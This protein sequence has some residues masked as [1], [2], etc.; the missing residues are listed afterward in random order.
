MK[1]F[2]RKAF[3]IVIMIFG[4][5]FSAS[6]QSISLPNTLAVLQ[7]TAD[8]LS[9]I[10]AKSL[11]FNSS[12]GLNWADAYVGKLV[13]S[14]P[15]HFGIGASF[16]VTTIDFPI[17]S[18]LTDMFGFKLPMSDLKLFKE[19]LVLPA[20]AA[21]ARIGG[22][23]LPFDIGAK[24][25]M[26]PP[27]KWLKTSYELDY[28]MAGADLRFAILDGKSKK[29][30]PNL[31]AGVGFNYLRGGL[32]A[33]VT[34][35]APTFD[36]ENPIDHI[37]H[38]LKVDDPTFRLFWETYGIEGKVQISKSFF[39]IT[40]YLGF[41]A[42]YSWSK[43]G[44]EV[45]TGASFDGHP[46]SDTDKEMIKAYLAYAGLNSMDFLVDGFS[47]TIGNNAWNFR[48]FGGLSINIF[49]VKVDATIMYNIL[50]RQLGASVGA[51]FQ[52]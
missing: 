49:M 19:R 30:L 45:K 4:V 46:L 40:P 9:G 7:E 51:R 21:E 32:G 48:A 31:S 14:A 41:G 38:S 25:G 8:D 1:L 35:V 22:I 50:D 5:V 34:G 36:F 15:P 11:P 43:A 47:S 44:Y 12:L 17:L 16:G 27:V 33:T 20:Y 2:P 18:K 6:S 52:L 23:F 24:F 13:P 39:I 26:L 28:K 42:G 37:N 29:M 10:L 3:L